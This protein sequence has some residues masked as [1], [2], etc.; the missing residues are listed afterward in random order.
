M[1]E[2]ERERERETQ[3]HITDSLAIVRRLIE[4]LIEIEKERERRRKRE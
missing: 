4:Q 1:I 3:Q 2:K